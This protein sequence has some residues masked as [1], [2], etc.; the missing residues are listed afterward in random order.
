MKDKKTFQKLY[1]WNVHKMKNDES[2]ER[3][4]PH[5]GEIKLSSDCAAESHQNLGI[6]G[7]PSNDSQACPPPAAPPPSGACSSS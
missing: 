4:H 3:P 7:I 1:C 6:M 2:T 5:L